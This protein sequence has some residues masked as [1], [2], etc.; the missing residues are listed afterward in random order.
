MN[1]LCGLFDQAITATEANASLSVAQRQ[2]YI[3]NLEKAKLTPMYMR[4]Y[5]AESYV[6]L[7]KEDVISMAQEWIDLA[8]KYG[9]THYGEGSNRLLN[10]IKEKYNLG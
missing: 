9:V 3:Q 8:E 4:L 5:N 1:D 2:T 10:V 6:E 7:T